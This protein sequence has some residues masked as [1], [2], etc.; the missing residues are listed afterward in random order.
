MTKINKNNGM[1]SWVDI[2]IAPNP[3]QTKAWMQVCYDY[4]SKYKY[5]WDCDFIASKN[6]GGNTKFD[7]SDIKKGDIVKV[8]GN[9]DGEKKI[10]YAKIVNN[11][12]SELEYKQI[13]KNKAIDT[14]KDQN[15]TDNLEEKVKNEIERASDADLEIIYAKL[16]DLKSD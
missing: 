8:S 6:K 4:D 16:Q 10:L 9:N 3:D 12:D 13:S 7:V 1:I 14:L 15:K 5:N 2:S 11:R